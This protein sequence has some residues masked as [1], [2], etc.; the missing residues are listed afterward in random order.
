[1]HVSLCISEE[2]NFASLIFLLNISISTTALA[3]AIFLVYSHLIIR[4]VVPKSAPQEI[5]L[6]P[7]IDDQILDQLLVQFI[8]AAT[9][10]S[11]DHRSVRKSCVLLPIVA[12]SWKGNTLYFK[13]PAHR[14]F[15]LEDTARVTQ[16]YIQMDN[17]SSTVQNELFKPSNKRPT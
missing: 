3:Y 7:S 2:F 1:M 14:T 10:Q 15:T 5:T 4:S 6:Q 11:E 9:T 16:L 13:S 17:I 8:Y 12:I